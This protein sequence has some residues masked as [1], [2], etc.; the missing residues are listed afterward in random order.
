M[1]ERGAPPPCQSD[2]R[3][4]CRRGR[5]RPAPQH[6]TANESHDDDDRVQPSRAATEAAILF[7]LFMRLKGPPSLKRVFAGRGFF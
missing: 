4:S 6:C 5:L 2:T 3:D 1:N 7:V